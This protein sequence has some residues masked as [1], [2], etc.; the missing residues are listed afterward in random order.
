MV[1]IYASKR[2]NIFYY[3][4]DII[5]IFVKHSVEYLNVNI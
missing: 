3:N 2:L 4:N 1:L 5:C